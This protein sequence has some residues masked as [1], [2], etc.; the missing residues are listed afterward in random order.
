MTNLYSSA[1]FIGWFAVGLSLVFSRVLKSDLPTLAGNFIGAATL[2]IAN[3]YLSAS[4]DSL[5]MLQAVLDTD[6][7][8]ATHV[9]TVTIGYSVTYLAGILGIV[10]IFA[11]P[12]VDAKQSK[13]IAGMIY[14]STCL[15]ILFSFLG[16]V[17]GGL[18]ADASWGR[19]WGWDPKENGA[20]LVVIWNA[21]ILHARWCGLAKN[22]GIALLAIGGIMVTTWS[23]FGTNQLG[24]G[25]HAY[26]FDKG[27]AEFCQ[28]TW[29][30]T[31]LLIGLG[32]IPF[33]FHPKAA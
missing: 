33:K 22:R 18:W 12:F 27:L 24:I 31:I 13:Y 1:I 7:W 28:Y 6:F 9:T 10:Y 32:L 3:V 17:L 15:A 21:L 26:G 29:E 14:G 11:R 20:V 30:G 2:Y 16:T 19:F 8:L 5:G 23:W 25:L 4:G